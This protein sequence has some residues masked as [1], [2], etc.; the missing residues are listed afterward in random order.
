MNQLCSTLMS[1]VP[2]ALRAEQIRD[3]FITGEIKIYICIK[4]RPFADDE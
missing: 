2:R 1:F 4:Q 3:S